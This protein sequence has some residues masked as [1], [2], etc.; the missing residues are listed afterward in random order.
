MAKFNRLPSANS[1][2]VTVRSASRSWIGATRVEWERIHRCHHCHHCHHCQSALSPSYYFCTQHLRLYSSTVQSYRS[3]WRFF[4][5]RIY[6]AQALCTVFLFYQNE[7]HIWRIW[8]A[9]LR[10]ID[11]YYEEDCKCCSHRWRYRHMGHGCCISSLKTCINL[12]G[13]VWCSVLCFFFEEAARTSKI[14]PSALA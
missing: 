12:Q 6:N 9:V 3:D 4:W 1:F 10:V 7:R 8:A 5:K 14:L 13:T 2:S 11:K